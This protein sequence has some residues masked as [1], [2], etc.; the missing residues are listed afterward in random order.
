MIRTVLTID[1]M[2]CGMC[3]AHVNDAIRAAIPVRKV[4]S[5]HRRGE[6]VLLTDRSPDSDALRR[7]LAAVGYTLK[8]V[9]EEE[10]P[11][12]PRFSLFRRA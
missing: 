2:S 9:R 6:A 4:T 8:A 7:A 10:A 5:S 3:E 11:E 1:G 12:K